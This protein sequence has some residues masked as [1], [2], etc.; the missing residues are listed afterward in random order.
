MDLTGQ[1]GA[2]MDCQLIWE[3]R[4]ARNAEISR[5]VNLEEHNHNHTLRSA[6]EVSPTGFHLVRATCPYGHGHGECALSSTFL[7]L[8]TVCMR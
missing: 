7:T 4:V 6:S 2:W 8:A 5:H 3:I 1:G